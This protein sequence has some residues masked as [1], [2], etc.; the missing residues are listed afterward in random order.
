MKHATICV[1]KMDGTSLEDLA[2]Y[3]NKDNALIFLFYIGLQ[4]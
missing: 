3:K 4:E 1:Q 2:Y